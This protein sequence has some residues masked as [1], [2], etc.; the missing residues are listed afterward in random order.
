MMPG[1]DPAS[2]VA[3][4]I[5]IARNPKDVA[6]SLY[7]HTRRVKITD[8]DGD[9]DCFFELFM[10]GKNTYG[11]WFDHVPEWWKHRGSVNAYKHST[12]TIFIIYSQILIIFFS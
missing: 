12:V 6:V 5:Y 4:F 3:K 11:S 8:F 9:W 1:G 10:E 2:S 7:Y